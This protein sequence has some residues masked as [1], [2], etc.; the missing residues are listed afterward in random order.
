MRED[1]ELN[2]DLDQAV[3]DR[4]AMR[5]GVGIRFPLLFLSGSFATPAAGGQEEGADERSEGCWPHHELPP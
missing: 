2:A 3:F 1:S 4:F 5:N